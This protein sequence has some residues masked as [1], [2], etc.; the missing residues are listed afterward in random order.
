M[1]DTTRGGL[2]EVEQTEQTQDGASVG[3]G[4]KGAKATVANESVLANMERL[5]AQKQAQTTGFGA[6]LEGLKD[7]AAWTSGGM[8]GPAEALALRQATKDKQA[9]ELFDMQTQIA[10]QKA[11]IANRNAFFGSGA[12]PGAATAGGTAGVGG[13]GGAGGGVNQ[14]NLA[15]GGLLNLVDDPAL[16]AQIGAT[17][18]Q[19][20]TRAMNQ[21]N[22]FLAKRAES[23]EIKKKMDYLASL[24]YP[25]DQ[26]LNLALLET[27]GSGS[28]KPFDVRGPMGTQQGTAAQAA[29]VFIPGSN[30]GVPGA[31]AAPGVVPPTS[32]G[33]TS[34]AAPVRSSLT[35]DIYVPSNARVAAD[36]NNP[37]GI[38]VS[39]R[40][41]GFPT[42]E[43]GVAATQRLVGARLSQNMTPD[44]L[45]GMWVT[46][47]PRQGATVAGGN[48]LANVRRELQ[49]AG[50]Q[51]NRDGTIP[52]T[53]AAN[54]AV[55]R[56]IIRGEAPASA[57]PRFL[58]HVDAGQP[59]AVAPA[60]V[61]PPAAAAPSPLPT[62][63]PAEVPA[64][65]AAA[66][67][68]TAAPAP[69]PTPAAPVAGPTVTPSAPLTTNVP[70]APTREDLTA[71]IPY[72]PGTPEYDAV[73]QARMKSQMDE[74]RARREAIE[75][76]AE[77]NRARVAG[78]SAEV[79]KTVKLEE[80]RAAG[81]RRDSILGV[82]QSAP[83]ALNR[84][85]TFEKLL[86]SSPTALGY[87]TLS[88]LKGVTMDVL[89]KQ[90]ILPIDAETAIKSVLGPLKYEDRRAALA[91]VASIALDYQKSIFQ[92]QGQVSNYER[93]Y[94]EQAK[95]LGDKNSLAWNLYFAKGME[96][97]INFAQEVKKGWGAYKDAM[98]KQGRTPLYSDFERSDFYLN[99]ENTYKN[100]LESLSGTT[101]VSSSNRPSLQ[102]LYQQGRR[103]Q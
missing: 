18:L 4:G 34:G 39:G 49:E 11:A 54:A 84:L 28:F 83:E 20:P 35:G 22:A 73:I 47:D 92:G 68:P 97:K 80:E 102:D 72:S 81:I 29:G 55:T 41:A 50:V 42:P 48:Y 7:A 96:H 40:Y 78:V 3:M 59:R 31:P 26:L 43:E 71:N 103:R 56:A 98:E 69:T 27:V 53:P 60:P 1:T 44:A 52:N 93:Q 74:E 90:K 82:A 9:R 94:A 32:A 87:E 2:P 46:G 5:F 51:L 64:A 38:M 10:A 95:G 13:A 37:S 89:N 101:F 45:V 17:Y 63:A 21:L 14:A 76:E 57:V 61:A 19:D 36:A 16:R 65:A 24:G 12:G 58:P 99:A 77:A 25:R 88:G 8:H 91:L 70:T 86:R 100:R 66:A 62:P 30:S 23:P 15:S 75:K 79:A 33:A 85:Q 6:I 67:A